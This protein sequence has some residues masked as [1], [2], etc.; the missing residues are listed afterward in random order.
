M[1]C[2]YLLLCVCLVLGFFVAVNLLEARNPLYRLITYSNQS[3]SV[4]AH[5][6]GSAGSKDEFP[7]IAWG[8][9]WATLRVDGWEKQN[10]PVYFGDSADILK[11]GA[12]MWANSRFCGQNG[13]TVLSAH[14][15]RHF[16]EIEDTAVGT[17]VT[18]ET[19]YGT[20]RYVVRSIEIFDPDQPD[21]L[22]ERHERESLVMYTCYPY[23]A[24]V[25]KQRIALVCEKTAG[26]EFAGYDDD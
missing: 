18:V 1:L 10:I 4:T 5:Q 17:G 26:K 22:L 15:T 16:R 6:D 7:V 25:R 20:Y 2:P 21:I 11:K 3:A 23:S 13:Q 24:R 14:V 8:E 9:Q 19:K 12:G